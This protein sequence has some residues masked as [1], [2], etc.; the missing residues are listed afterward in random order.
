[1]DGHRLR[2][3]GRS[4][5]NRDQLQNRHQNKASPRKIQICYIIQTTILS[6]LTPTKFAVKKNK[7]LEVITEEN[8][9]A[10]FFNSHLFHHFS[11][12]QTLHV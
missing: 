6:K 7:Y 12:Q 10:T 11:L 2:Y 3:C 9:A 1:M 8:V 4:Q 5:L